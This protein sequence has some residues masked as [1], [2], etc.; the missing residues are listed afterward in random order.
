MPLAGGPVIHGMLITRRH[1]G[2][3]DEMAGIIV[4]VF[5]L[6]RLGVRRG[7]A[8]VAQVRGHRS[9]PALLSVRHGGVDGRA[10]TVALLR[11]T[12]GDDGLRDGDARFRHAHKFQRRDGSLRL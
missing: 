5:V 2:L 10:H 11:Q 7:I 12:D 9:Q 8:L 6:R 4:G 3:F 1:I